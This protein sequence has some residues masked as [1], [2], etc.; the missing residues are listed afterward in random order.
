MMKFILMAIFLC[1]SS[2]HAL[3]IEVKRVSDGILIAGDSGNS[4]TV[5]SLRAKIMDSRGIDILDPKYV[6]SH[7]T[8]VS[9]KAARKVRR[10]SF[11][12][13]HPKKNAILLRLIKQYMRRNDIDPEAI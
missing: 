1:I 2:A 5:Q 12:L 3:E 8:R 10:A 7:P 6:I 4:V 13:A 9:D 11:T